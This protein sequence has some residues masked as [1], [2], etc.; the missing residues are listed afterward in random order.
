LARRRYKVAQ[1][2]IPSDRRK[3][4]I[5]DIGCGT[6]PLFLAG[7][8]FS[9]KIGLD[10]SFNS[11]VADSFTTPGFKLIEHDIE[12]GGG[13]PLKN[14]CCDVVTML[15]V[16]EHIERSRLEGLLPEVYRILK[17]G[18]LYVVTTP[19]PW[20]DTLLRIM[21]RLNLVS[22]AEIH[23][24]KTLFDRAS[25]L[26]MLAKAGFREENIRGGYFELGLNVWAV[27]SRT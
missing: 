27:A 11:G 6:F 16:I 24:H 2:L 21:A 1:S 13:L 10:K 23:E 3:G 15:A 14:N 17:P 4:C 25:L 8:D 18:G 12:D 22:P 9:E 26:E 19:A 20:T 5:A 7:I